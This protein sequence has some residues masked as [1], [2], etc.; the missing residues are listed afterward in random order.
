MQATMTTLCP[1]KVRVDCTEMLTTMMTRG[2]KR[3]VGTNDT[4][5]M[6]V[7]L[8]SQNTWSS[9]NEGLAV[10]DN[11][12]DADDE[13]DENDENDVNFG[14]TEVEND[15]VDD[16][17]KRT[18]KVLDLLYPNVGLRSL[19]VSNLRLDSSAESAQNS[20]PT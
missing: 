13:N 6:T 16:E 18:T 20:Y 12:D 1:R 7:L 4:C 19:S 11:D 5:A 17:T 2:H 15:D 9:G 14:P 8:K 10:S 3:H